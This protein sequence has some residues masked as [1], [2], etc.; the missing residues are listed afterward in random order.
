[1]Q[2]DFLVIGSGI[3]GLTSAIK[4]SQ[5]GKVT[6]LTKSAL[7]DCATALA[8]GGIASVVAK[9]D[10]TESHYLDTIS[11]GAGLCDEAAVKVLVEEG[12]ARIKDIVNWGLLFDLDASGGYALG[13]EAAHSCNRVLHTGDAT[14]Q[15]IH[16][17]LLK[18]AKSRPSISIIQNIQVVRLLVSH[19]VCHGAETEG[20]KFYSASAVILATGGLGQLY[21][22]TTNPFGAQG[23]GFV[24]AYEAGAELVDLEFVQFHPTGFLIPIKGLPQQLISEAVRGE[25]AVLRNVFRQ[26]FVDELAPRDV[27]TRAINDEMHKTQSSHVLLD[28]SPI[29]ST[30]RQRFPYIYRICKEAR[31]NITKDLVPVAPVAH[32][33]M[34]GVKTGLNGETNILNLYAVGEVACTGVDGAN[35]LAS[36]SLLAGLVFAHRAVEYI[37]KHPSIPKGKFEYDDAKSALSFNN[38]AVLFQIKEILWNNVGICRS[39]NS[40]KTALNLLEKLP[41]NESVVLLAKLIAKASLLRQESRGAHFRQDHPALS[42]AGHAAHYVFQKNSK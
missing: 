22:N 20:G 26:R 18:E 12:P 1:M 29:N 33:F 40:L 5:F 32:Y 28:M 8:Q 31:V 42:P 17:I 30:V 9:E 15:A 23:D 3:A 37:K 39:E 4:L 41:E 10:T 11:A 6:I 38:P 25:G 13:R 34:G 14:G 35:R 21:K 16:D 27:V 36:N 2:T 7:N 24:L 19:G